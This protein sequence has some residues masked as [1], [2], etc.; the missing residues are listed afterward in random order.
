MHPVDIV[1]ILGW[2]AFW[3]YWLAAASNVKEGRSRWARFAGIRFAA[4]VI[5]VLLFR[6]HVF[7]DASPTDDPW[8]QAVGLG[9]FFSGLGVAIW[10]RV[11]L[12]RNWGTPMTEK[13]DPELVTTGPYRRIR[14]PIYA[15]ILLAGVGTTV[16]VSLYWL[17]AVVAMGLSFLLSAFME[18]RF[19]VDRFPD[20]YPRYKRSTKMLIPFIF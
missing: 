14:H 20:L 16:A 11:D 13:V 5:T 8:L 10:A 15:G 3:L 18:E 7:G 17:V 4:V 19:M 9:V 6:T 2:I 12:G 1:I